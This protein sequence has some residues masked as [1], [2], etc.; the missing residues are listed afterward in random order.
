MT[1]V[2]SRDRQPRGVTLV[3]LL[4]VL[5]VLAVLVSI[6]I[7]FGTRALQEA[8]QQRLV[9]VG[10]SLF[11]AV[12]RY[13]ADHGHP[14]WPGASIPGGLNLRTLE[15]LHGGGYLNHSAGLVEPLRDGRVT[16]YDTPGLPGS[17]GF[18]LLLVDKNRPEVQV[19]AASTDEFPLAPGTHLEG[20][21]LV[22]GHRLLHVDSPSAPTRSA[23][24][25]RG[26]KKGRGG[27]HG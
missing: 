20:I 12:E 22:R 2:L 1:R 7:P 6:S 10:R 23:R 24:A 27:R 15:P 4:V 18:W 17:E 13:V 9:A 3:E 26:P 5:G 21:Y 25:N 19:L 8:R 16:A 11:V 14:P